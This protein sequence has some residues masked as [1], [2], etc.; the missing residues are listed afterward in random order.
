MERLLERAQDPLGHR[1]SRPFKGRRS[2]DPRLGGSTQRVP[3]LPD[4]LYAGTGLR[5]R[6]ESYT[7]QDGARSRDGAPRH[8]QPHQLTLSRRGAL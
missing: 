7:D 2:K 1:L 4:G 8:R 5:R 3:E 6:Q